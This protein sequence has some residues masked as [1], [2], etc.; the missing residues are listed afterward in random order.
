MVADVIVETSDTTTLVLF[1]GNEWRLQALVQVACNTRTV[2]T[3]KS[4]E[5]WFDTT[6]RSDRTMTY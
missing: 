3:T 1:T 5:S 4:N 6:I 2:A